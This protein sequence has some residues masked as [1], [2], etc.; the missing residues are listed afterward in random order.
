MYVLQCRDRGRSSYQVKPIPHLGSYLNY[1][2]I[3]F[4][5]RIDREAQTRLRALHE[6]PIGLCHDIRRALARV[7]AKS[8]CEFVS[9][10][11]GYL[12]LHAADCHL[13][14]DLHESV[15]YGPNRNKEMRLI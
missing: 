11:L 2:M 3:V 7:S 13:N 12:F 9:G 14:K 5:R 6:R 4:K 8:V 15:A 1:G 10:R